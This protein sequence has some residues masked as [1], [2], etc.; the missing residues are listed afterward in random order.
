MFATIC[1]GVTQFT[2]GRMFDRRTLKDVFMPLAIVQ[3]PALLALSFLDG[4]IVLPLSALVAAAIFGQVTVNETMTARY[5]AP[6][7]RVRLY[8]LRFF[9]GFMGAAAAAPLVGL[10]HEATGGLAATL[11][12]LA[13]VSGVTLLCAFFFP[14]REEELKPE[15]WAVAP[16]E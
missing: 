1:G 6:P 16:A 3:G 5:I 14:D 11:V 10:L 15:L 7:L 13:L 2:V 12:V 9:I 4:W 8:S